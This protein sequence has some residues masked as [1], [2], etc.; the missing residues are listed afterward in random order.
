M[1]KKKIAVYWS[2]SCGGCDVSLLD[3]ETNLLELTEL[4]DIVYWPVAMDFKRDAFMALPPGSVDI[5][6]FNGAIRTSDPRTLG[7]PARAAE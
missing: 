7:G 1:E 3:I 6:I 5:G 4:A 2:A